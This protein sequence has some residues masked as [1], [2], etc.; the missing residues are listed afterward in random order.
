M[1]GCSVRQFVQSCAQGTEFC[2]TL[3]NFRVV[4]L[5][6]KL[7]LIFLTV[8]LTIISMPHNLLLYLPLCNKNYEVSGITAM[9]FGC[10]TRLY[11]LFIGRQYAVSFIGMAQS[12]K[13]NCRKA[14][15]T[16]GSICFPRY[17]S[18]YC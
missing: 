3:P 8:K 7:Q 6:K 11:A 10:V 12:Y 5:T 15:V 2:F 4:F 13:V 18:L 1:Y 9:R 14:F 16:A 17:S